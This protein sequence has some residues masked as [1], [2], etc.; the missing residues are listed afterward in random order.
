MEEYMDLELYN[1]QTEMIIIGSLWAN[2][3]TFAY[4]Y[5]DVINN[6]DFH[7]SACRFFHQLLNHYINEYSTEVT[8]QKVNMYV[9]Q[10][11]GV[12]SG[13]KKYGCFKTIKEFMKYAV[14]SSDEMKRQVDV[15]KK[16]SVL[17]ALQEDG[18][19][20]E[21][22]LAEPKFN[23]MSAEQVG[24]LV[25]GRVDGICNATLSNIDDPVLLTGNA[26]GIAE[27]FLEAPA[28]GYNLAFN[29]MNE[30]FLGAIPSDVLGIAMTS[31]S[32]KSRLLTYMMMYTSCV[33][34]INCGMISNEMSEDAM[35]TASFTTLFNCP[36]IQNLH[37]EYIILPQKRFTSGWYKNAAGDIIKRNFD[38]NGVWSE[39]I[40]QF[41][42]RVYKESAEYRS[43]LNALKWYEERQR[44]GIGMLWFKDVMSSGYTDEIVCRTAR[45]MVLSKGCEIWGYD[46]CKHSSDSQIDK[47]GDL[48]RTVSTLS[49]LNKSLNSYAVLTMQ[50]NNG[51][52]ERPIEDIDSSNIASA[53]Y[54]YQILDEMVVFKHLDKEDCENYIIKTKDKAYNLNPDVRHSVCKILKNR[55][56][57][58]HM[59][60]LDID[61]NTNIWTETKEGSILIPKPK[62][63]K[64]QDLVW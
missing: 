15:L 52:L 34:G 38:S 37:G 36:Q 23:S 57:E 8:E 44:N 11:N 40:E 3:E 7:D 27:G 26:L 6:K 55:R 60:C 50:L 16:W 21:A 22:I 30:A 62:K 54:T 24:S 2:T 28:R 46:T 20:V 53:S 13:Y 41:K 12:M 51:A 59:H 18:Y 49:E 43:V 29:F 32:G 9:S 48:V 42:A 25:R 5:I 63:K 64:A 47:W 35:K 1:T 14:S 33:E 19:N 4:D 39:T 61:L 10:K 45:Q 17:R 31:N 56:G 58:K